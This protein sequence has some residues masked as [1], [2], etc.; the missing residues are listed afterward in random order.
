MLPRCESSILLAAQVVVAGLLRRATAED[1]ARLSHEQFRRARG[2]GRPW[3]AQRGWSR[4]L[5]LAARKRGPT[6]GPGSAPFLGSLVAD[7]VEGRNPHSRHRSG[8]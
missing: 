4:S 8:R 2:G 5:T 1:L 6:A 3:A 7:A